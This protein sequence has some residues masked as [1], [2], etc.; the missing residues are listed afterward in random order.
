MKSILIMNNSMHVFIEG[1]KPCKNPLQESG[2]CI[3]LKDC[4]KVFKMLEK[5][6]ISPRNRQF[7][8]SSQCGFKEVPYVCCAH[9]EVNGGNFE[10]TTTKKPLEV[11]R[12]SEPQW[13]KA[14]K[15]KVPQSPHCGFDSIDRIFG[16]KETEIDEFPWLVLVEYKKREWKSVCQ[17]TMFLFLFSSANNRTGFHCGGS[18][19]NERYVL[20]GNMKFS[21]MP[22]IINLFW[23]FHFQPHIA[24]RKFPQ[25]G[26]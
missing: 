13:L 23:L 26:N 25:L 1:N 8:K 11:P 9:N 17:A 18:L 22:L 16:G 24:S 4:H 2:T 7:L 20:T 10:E 12:N 15:E 6:P 3:K 5:K 14:L 21:A 19:I